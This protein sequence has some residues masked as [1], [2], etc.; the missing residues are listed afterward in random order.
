VKALFLPEARHEVIESAQ[1]YESR[2]PGLGLRFKNEIVR[3]CVRIVKDP[4]LWRERKGG[5]RRVNCPNFPYYVAYLIREE[6]V[7][8]VAVAHGHRLPEYWKARIR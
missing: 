1:Y 6:T 3:V 2:L 8:I 5:Y 7:V 4:L